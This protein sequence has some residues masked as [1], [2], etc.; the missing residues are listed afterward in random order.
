MVK[1]GDPAYA[2]KKVGF[3]DFLCEKTIFLKVFDPFPFL[4]DF[5]LAFVVWVTSQENLSSEFATS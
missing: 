3:L 4:W 2:T 5:L 1:A